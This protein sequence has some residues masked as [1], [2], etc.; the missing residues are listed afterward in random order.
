[1]YYASMLFRRCV[2]FVSLQSHSLPFTLFHLHTSHPTLH[3]TAT[4]IP[5]YMSQAHNSRLPWQ[6]SNPKHISFFT[7]CLAHSYS[8][9][10]FIALYSLVSP[11]PLAKHSSFGCLIS[12]SGLPPIYEYNT[13]STTLTFLTIKLSSFLIKNPSG[14]FHLRFNF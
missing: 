14:S 4:A 12:C 9:G 3:N 11:L 7:T 2:H 10:P 13:S 8:P 1:M 5:Y 6:S